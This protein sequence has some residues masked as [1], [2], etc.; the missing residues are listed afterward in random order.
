MRPIES[1]YF[2]YR[3]GK[4]RLRRWIV[5]FF[6]PSFSRYVEPFVG[7]ANVYLMARN[8]FSFTE[9]VLND[10]Q[11]IPW[12]RA[13]LSYDGRPLPAWSKEEAKQ[14]RESYEAFLMEPIIFWAGGLRHQKTSVTGHRGHNL[15]TYRRRLLEAQQLLRGCYLTEME[16]CEMLLQVPA[17]SFVYLDPPYLKASVG[18]YADHMLNREW[19]IE[20]LKRAP[21]PWLLSEYECQDL[22][23]AFGGPVAR[24]HNVYVTP[25]PKMPGGKRMIEALYS[26]YDPRPL[27]LDFQDSTSPSKR[28]IELFC[29]AGTPLSEAGFVAL[30][31][32]LWSPAV[33]ESEFHKLTKWPYA[34]FD[35]IHL[36]PN[37]ESIA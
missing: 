36:F 35:G 16:A 9:A 18:S 17:D 28:A 24:L 31:S 22:N 21:Y 1:P 7:R 10:L 26:N 2:V 32:E 4:A 5:R 19:M 23:E 27:A 20:I 29:Q 11:T 8:L 13:I 30:G 33:A 15:E 12:L 6:P 3:G 34:Y 14:M 25:S 37:H